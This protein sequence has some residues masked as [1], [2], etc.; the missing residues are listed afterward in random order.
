L[1]LFEDAKLRRAAEAKAATSTATSSPAR[2]GWLRRWLEPQGAPIPEAADDAE[3]ARLRQDLASTREYLQSVIEQQEAAN[4]ELRSASEEILSA[5]EELQSTNEELETA[6][7]ELQSTNEELNTIN[8]QLQHRNLDLTRLNDDMTNLLGSANVAMLSVG[9][10]LRLRRFTPVATRVL[11]V[12]PADIGEPISRMRWPFD[13]RDL[14]A[15]LA[16]VVE[17]VQVREREVHDAAGHWY[18]L[19]VH[20]YRTSDNR[21]DGTVLVFQNIDAIKSSEV[22]MRESRDFSQAV[23]ETVRDPLIILDAELRVLGANRAFHQI[24]G[25]GEI[26]KQRFYEIG[27][28]RWNDPELRRLLTEQR[29]EQDVLIDFELRQEIEGQGSRVLL[30]NAR[31]IARRDRGRELMLLSISDVTVRNQL[32]LESRRHIDVLSEADRRKTEFLATL[33]HELRNPLAPLRHS[34]EILRLAGGDHAMAEHAHEVMERQ[35]QQITR[36]VDDLLDVSRLTQGR[37]ELRRERIDLTET[38]RQ[39]VDAHRP[40][41]SASGQELVDRL[42]TEPLVV[43]ADPVRMTQVVENLLLNAAKYSARGTR[44]ELE[45]ESEGGDAVI[46]VRDSGIGIAPEMLPRIFDLFMP[47]DPTLDR[48]GAGLGI[49]L[50]L[51]RSLVQMHGGSVEAQSAGVG[52]GSEFTVRVPLAPSAHVEVRPKRIAPGRPRRILVVDDSADQA[53]SLGLLLELIGNEVRVAQN[54]VDAI[55]AAAEF[56]PE[57]AFLDIGLPGMDGYEIARRLRQDAGLANLFLIALS[58]YGTD[59]DRRRAREAGFDLHLTKPVL[60]DRLRSALAEIPEPPPTAE[61]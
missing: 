32:A 27:D 18:E 55:A 40:T 30:L 36:L 28:G 11:N 13:L 37:I 44:I 60:P 26:V 4:E 24:A 38:L 15:L 12:G 54:G 53:E 23:V 48:T 59:E 43:D 14:D 7:E 33:S 46:R 8:E 49:G 21:I 35:L 47:V 61:A 19:R 45:T 39:I 16:E 22:A 41:L 6:K 5:N 51:V 3:V 52:R 58:G 31:R 56:H 10:D 29:P 17:T 1:V 42:T 9:I 2:K 34:L 20:P 25:G 50:T 57:V